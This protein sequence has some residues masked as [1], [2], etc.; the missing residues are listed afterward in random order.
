MQTILKTIG[1]PAL[2]SLLLILPFMIMEVVNRRNFN[3]DFP[4]MLFFVM[5]LNLFAISLIL[6]PIARSRRIG[7]HDMANPVPTQGNTLLINPRSAAMISVVLVLSLVIVS[8]LDSL[9]WAP[10][11]RLL[12]GPN[13]EQL[14]VFRVRVPSQ[15][16]ALI[17]ISIPVVAGIIAGG[18]IVSTLRAGGSLFAHP[19]NLIIVVVISFLFAAGVVGMIVDQWPCFIGVPNCD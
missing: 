12:N 17:L 4:F 1:S 10:M 13:P 5:W 18:P 15:F 16:I 14:Y 2:I 8:L 6:L 3:E 7:N 11:E 9:G 19:I